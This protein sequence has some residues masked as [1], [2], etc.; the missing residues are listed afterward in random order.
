VGNVRLDFN[1]LKE[2]SVFR[3]IQREAAVDE[4]I[5]LSRVLWIHMA[6]LTFPDGA[7]VMSFGFSRDLAEAQK[8]AEAEFHEEFKVWC[9][10]IASAATLIGYGMMLQRQRDSAQGQPQDINAQSLALLAN[11]RMPVVLD[12]LAARGIHVPWLAAA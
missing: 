2:R 4:S 3:F 10:R 1:A 11:G 12:A 9:R 7:K 5:R 6:L 8:D